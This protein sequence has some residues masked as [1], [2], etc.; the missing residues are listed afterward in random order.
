[1]NECELHKYRIQEGGESK[2]CIICGKVS[3][4]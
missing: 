4:D 2:R 3:Y 1:M